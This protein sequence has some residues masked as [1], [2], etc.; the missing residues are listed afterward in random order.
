MESKTVEVQAQGHG[1]EFE[2]MKKASD[3]RHLKRIKIV[4]ELF[5]QSFNSKTYSPNEKRVNRIKELSYKI[6]TLIAKA[7]PQFPIDRIAK[8]DVAILRL[9]IYE[10]VFEKKEPPKVIID[11]AVEI[12][13]KLGGEASPAFVNGVLGTIFKK[14]E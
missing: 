14:N 5:A 10:L 4:Q 12:A 11:E 8:I 3:P 2:S 7:A 13:K 9:A 1:E 6:D